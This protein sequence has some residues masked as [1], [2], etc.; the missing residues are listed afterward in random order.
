MPQILLFILSSLMTY[1]NAT[2]NKNVSFSVMQ[3]NE[4][5]GEIQGMKSTFDEKIIYTCLTKAT[6]RKIIK[7]KIA[8][9][10]EVQMEAGKM[11]ASD[12]NVTVRGAIYAQNHIEYCEADC[13]EKKDEKTHY[14]QKSITYTTTMLYFEEP[15]NINRVYSELDGSF[16]TLKNKGNHVYEKITPDGEKSLFYYQNGSLLKAKLDMGVFEFKI[17]K[18]G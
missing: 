16:H 3:Y 2:L 8:S 17:V 1:S 12:A 7:I 11:K 4:K 13:I 9:E 5:V 18:E 10:Y 15:I 6:P 14:I